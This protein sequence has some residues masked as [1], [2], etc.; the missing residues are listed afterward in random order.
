MIE[1]QASKLTAIL[2]DLEQRP[3]GGDVNQYPTGPYPC[4]A[5]YCAALIGRIDL[6]R[7]VLA[8]DP[9]P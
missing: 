8:L 7:R 4:P 9:D 3:G 2:D 5:I 1:A 6:A